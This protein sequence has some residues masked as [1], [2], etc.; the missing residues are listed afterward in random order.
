M[1][2]YRRPHNV[3]DELNRA[4]VNWEDDIEKD[5]KCGKPRCQIRRLVGDGC[6]FQENRTYFI[7][8]SFDCDSAGVLYPLFY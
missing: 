8:F 4:K 6:R 2:V 7:N 3:K 5:M 1:I